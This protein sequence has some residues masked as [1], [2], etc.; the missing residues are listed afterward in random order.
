MRKSLLLIILLFGV[1]NAFAQIDPCPPPSGGTEPPDPQQCLCQTDA[2]CGLDDLD[3]Y[4]LVM[5]SFNTPFST[6]PGC[7]GNVLNNPNWFSFVAGSTNLSIVIEPTDCQGSGSMGNTGIQAAIYSSGDPGIGDPCNTCN[8][9]DQDLSVLRT[10]CGCTTGNITWNNLATMPGTTYYIVIDGCGGDICKINIDVIDGGDPPM[11]GDP[12]MLDPPDAHFSNDSVCAGATNYPIELGAV[13]GAGYYLWN[14]PGGTQE[15]TTDPEL[16]LSGPL[17]PGTYTYEVFAANDCDTS[18]LS[19]AV[20]II[21]APIPE[22]N[23]ADVI[24]EGDTYAWDIPIP[25]TL[26]GGTVQN[27]TAV[28]TSDFGCPYNANLALTIINENDENPTIINTAVC[29][30]EAYALL[31][32]SYNGGIV[33]QLTEIKGQAT[34][35]CDTFFELTIYEMNAEFDFDPPVQNTTCENGLITV[36]PITNIVE[37]DPTTLPGLVVEYEWMRQATGAIYVH[38]YPYQ[39]GEG[40]ECLKIHVD[41]FLSDLEN[42]DL[43]VTMRY[44]GGTEDK[45]CIFG[46]FNVQLDRRNFIPSIPALSGPM[47]ICLNADPTVVDFMVTDPLLINQAVAIGFNVDISEISSQASI[48]L[49]PTPGGNP[50]LRIEFTGAV[51]G[52]I[53]VSAEGECVD[54]EPICIPVNVT[55]P[56][57]GSAGNYAAQCEPT[58]NLDAMGTPGEWSVVMQPGSGMVTFSDPNDPS[59]I[60]S[61]P[62]TEKGIYQ[63]AWTVGTAECFSTFTTDIIIGAGPTEV[64]G[65]LMTECNLSAD[66]YTYT[67]ELEGGVLPYSVVSGNAIFDPV[68]ST[69]L[70]SLSEVA[71]GVDD[72]I[73]VQDN[74]GCESTITVE[75]PNCD[76]TNN[77][78]TMDL[79]LLTSCT[80]PITGLHNNDAVLIG[81]NI[82]V[83]YLHDLNGTVI[84]TILDQNTTGTFSFIDGTMSY[85]QTYYISYVIGDDEGGGVIDLAGECTKVAAGQPVIW[86]S[87]PEAI[88]D[89]SLVSTCSDSIFLSAQP[90]IIG[91]GTWTITSGPAGATIS[92]VNDP[93]ALFRGACGMYVVT[94]EVDNNGCSS[95]AFQNVEINCAPELVAGSISRICDATRTSYDLSF[96]VMGGE[97][98]YSEKNGRIIPTGSVFSLAGL[99]TG[100]QET[101]IVVDNNGC[102]LQVILDVFDCDCMADIAG[103]LEVCG[104]TVTLTANG[105]G[106]SGTW[107]G[108]TGNPVFTPNTTD[109][110]TTIT[111]DSYGQHCFNWNEVC[112]NSNVDAQYCV[113]FL[114]SPEVDVT[115]IMPVCDGDFENYAITFD[116]TGGESATYTVLGNGGTLTGDRFVSD[117]IPSGDAYEFRVSDNKS[118]GVFIIQGMHDCGCKSQVGT[119]NTDRVNLCTD[120][121]FDASSSYDVTNEDRDDNDVVIYVLHDGAM[122]P[123]GNILASNA[124]GQFAFDP[125]Y[126]AGT[127]YFVTVLVGSE[128]SGGNID[129][130]DNCLSPSAAKEIVWF[131]EPTFNLDAS[132]MI[133]T[134]AAKSSELSIIDIPNIGDYNILW[135]TSDGSIAPGEEVIASPTISSPGTYVATLSHILAGCSNSESITITASSDLPV[136]TGTADGQI[137]CENLTVNISGLGSSTDAGVRYEWTGTGITTDPTMLDIT[138]DQAGGFV[139]RVL[140]EN[141][142]CDATFN[143]VVTEDITPP[144]VMANASEMID[145]NTDEVSV[146]GA[147]SSTG[148]NFTYM[149]STGNGNIVSGGSTISATVDAVGDYNLV[150]RNTD[151]GC[152]SDA[153][154]SVSIDDNTI[155]GLSIGIDQDV[156]ELDTTGVIQV[157]GVDGGQ[158]PYTY[159]FDNGNSFDVITMSD[160]RTSGDYRVIVRDANGCEFVDTARIFP[161]NSFFVELGDP[162]LVD[163][164]DEVTLFAQTNLALEDI[165]SIVW[166]PLND[167]LN[168]DSLTQVYVPDFGQT[169]VRVTLISE[170]GCIAQDNVNITVLFSQ[171]VYVPNAMRPTSFVTANQHAFIFVNPESV[172]KIFRFSIYDRWGERVFDRVDVPTSNTLIK[173]YAWDGIGENG[174][175]SPVGVYSYVAEVEFATGIKKVLSGEIHLID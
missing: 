133:I 76:C 93:T 49:S 165:N 152:E 47:E 53:C 125:S 81:A 106:N 36:C 38:N 146:D 167:T 118:C 80:D 60:M 109:R 39:P 30:G 28:R 163:L 67:L 84:G 55:E 79:T 86:Y 19:S 90:A 52:D 44:T 41:D 102:E 103:D 65:S 164:G 9:G 134:C 43:T 6:F 18:E 58:V 116:I 15:R 136:A 35:G 141:T 97:A 82:G 29:E 111:V 147:G 32:Q 85:D 22:E 75:S 16:I 64:A 107:T 91:Q 162:K 113:T 95:S 121:V 112:D 21:V 46:P 45:E 137:T 127:S 68:G 17:L 1:F 110:V 10:Q 51:T 108:T 78:G 66:G 7:G 114:D 149:W 34:S 12:G 170:A 160:E 11:A 144:I 151:N 171:D 120:A 88:V 156:C 100:V 59:A 50:I 132:E 131:E 117:P 150:V 77:P 33:D 119:L 48:A 126:T 129:L 4:C 89:A 24:C 71:E 27:F 74:D 54:S 169:N 98:P 145:C 135:T 158:S 96:E 63:V 161:S 57:S 62:P 173:E 124:T 56:P 104:R 101:F 23:E 40:E 5:Q 14:L 154:T 172:S 155:K 42:F 20:T 26:P 99:P 122:T 31:G 94:W 153:S 115:L 142:G 25:T 175:T 143:V 92:D 138:V 3:E 87:T 72:V 139:L 140:N 157:L 105:T 128:S 130:L 73:I 159:S 148:N 168:V 174:E 37:P 123:F 83:Y 166:A 2:I 69:T 61:V 8:P 13:D 70:V